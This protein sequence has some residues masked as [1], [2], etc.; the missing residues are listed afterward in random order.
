MS[1]VDL[2]AVFDEMQGCIR[3]S[4]AAGFD[5]P[6][7]IVEATVEMLSD[8]RDPAVIRAHARRM[9]REALAVQL[10][11]QNAWPART[12]C[13]RLDAAF[14]ALEAAGILC[15]QHYQCCGTCGVAAIWDE[16]AAAQAEGRNIRGYT[17]YH[18]QDTERAVD[19]DGLYLNYGAVDESENAACEIAHEVVAVL[20][21]HGL[22]TD[23]NGQSNRR[24]HIA[25]DWKR[26]RL[27]FIPTSSA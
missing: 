20:E 4:L 24:I 26:R 1:A 12:D 14:A 7:D 22:R 3:A 18:A 23:W 17:F 6:D 5:S 15:R 10:V 9:M 8:S 25:L 16:I 13:D 2:P 21:Q 19:G 27:L 11:E